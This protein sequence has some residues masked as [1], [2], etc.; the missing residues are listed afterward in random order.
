MD[1]MTDRFP[2]LQSSRIEGFPDSVPWEFV[3]PHRKQAMSNHYQTLERLAQRGG[4][5]WTELLDIVSGKENDF[6]MIKRDEAQRR[7]MESAKKIM[8]M[9]ERPNGYEESKESNREG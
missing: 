7:E 3:E 5:G 9:L 6:R 2:I 8:A 1:A 4:L